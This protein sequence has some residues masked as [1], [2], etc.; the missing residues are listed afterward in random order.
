[1]GLQHLFSRS[2]HVIDGVTAVDPDFSH[3]RTN[4]MEREVDFQEVFQRKAHVLVKP[5]GGGQSH[6]QPVAFGV[7]RY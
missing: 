7:C 1:M 4:A 2:K 3:R 6:D 5:A